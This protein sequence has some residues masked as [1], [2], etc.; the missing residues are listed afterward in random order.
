MDE[1]Q[2]IINKN[3]EH[4]KNEVESGGHYTIP[5]LNLN[6][7]LLQQFAKGELLFWS[8]PCAKINN[9]LLKKIRQYEYADIKGK[10]VLCLASGG[11][12][13]SAM[14]SLLGADVTVADITQGQLNGD[15]QA[16]NHYGYIVK[17]VQCS[18]TDLSVFDD[19]S[20][21]I[22]HQ[23]IS[24]CFVP[25]VA[26]VYKEVF[27]V[28]RKGGLYH[29]DHIN[30]ATH[31]T[32]Y[33]NSID[34]WDGIGFR[35]G[36]P[37]IGGPLRI[38][39][40]GNENMTSGEVDGEFRHLFIDIFCKLT[41]AGFQIKYIWEDERNLVTALNPQNGIPPCDGS[42]ES[43]FSVIQRYINVLSSK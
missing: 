1:L 5:D 39:E 7:D 17:T 38:D 23:P 33:E 15:I 4:W 19:E 25:D 31:P 42:Y 3:Q 18:M 22:V 34:G 10:K 21:D 27:R 24:I 13:Q 16:A 26:L 6:T 28:L 32:S 14:F 30:P 29:V 8:D 36:S 40:N 12:Q 35:I 37:Y 2:D 9:P 43:G 41:E 11:G 20:F